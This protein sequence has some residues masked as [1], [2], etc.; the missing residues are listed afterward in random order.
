MKYKINV[1]TIKDIEEHLK[2]VGLPGNPEKIRKNATT[3]EAWD[4]ELIGLLAVYETGY[5]TNLSVLSKY[6]NQGIATKLL[7]MA[8]S[9]FK[10]FELETNIPDFYFKH[11]F[12]VKMYR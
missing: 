9:Q 10:H 8:Y 7:K 11:G 2:K 1:A 6:R 3:F 4:N 12:K 5:I